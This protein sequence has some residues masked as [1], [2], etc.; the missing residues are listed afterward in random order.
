MLL[1]QEYIELIKSHFRSV[2]DLM[3]ANPIAFSD[4]SIECT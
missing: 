1:Q 3:D 2:H 4:G